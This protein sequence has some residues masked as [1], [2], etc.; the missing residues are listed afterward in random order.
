MFKKVCKLIQEAHEVIE[1]ALNFHEA[2]SH[3]WMHDLRNLSSTPRKTHRVMGIETDDVRLMRIAK[4]SKR[5]HAAIK[6]VE[7]IKHEANLLGLILDMSTSQSVRE[8]AIERIGSQE[9]LFLL[10]LH[11]E[12]M[13]ALPASRRLTDG[14]FVSAV[15]KASPHASVRMATAT[16]CTDESLLVYVEGHDPH[17]GVRW[18][19]SEKFRQLVQRDALETAVSE[20]LGTTPKDR[21][22]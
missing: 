22:N 9:Q 4:R 5:S 7:L 16:L 14:T 1:I 3:G 17:E 12:V 13:I 21:L 10:A 6:A 20:T 18:E 19:A 8:A 11:R 15:L 2:M